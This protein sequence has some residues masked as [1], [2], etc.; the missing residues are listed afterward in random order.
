MNPGQKNQVAKNLLG[1]SYTGPIFRFNS[2]FLKMGP[3]TGAF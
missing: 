2:Y 1:G 3:N